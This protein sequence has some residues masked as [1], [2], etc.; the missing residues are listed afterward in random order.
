MPLFLP[1]SFSNEQPNW[2]RFATNKH[3]F[4]T[5]YQFRSLTMQVVRRLFQT[6]VVFPYFS[7]GPI[8]GST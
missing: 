7:I 5:E 4:S 8:R 1:V 3:R 2:A 6:A